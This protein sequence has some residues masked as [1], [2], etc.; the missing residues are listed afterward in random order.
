M[1]AQVVQFEDGRFMRVDFVRH[2]EEMSELALEGGGTI[3]VP[4]GRI[5]NWTDLG[6][7]QAA[8]AAPLQPLAGSGPWVQAA[9]DYAAVIARAAAKHRLHPALLTAMAEVES[10]F[11]PRAVSHKGAQGLLQLMPGTA[12]RFGVVDSFDPAQNVE[13][14]AEYISWLL[15]R[16]AG[17]A[18]L[19][20]AGYNAGEGKVERY[21]GIPPYSETRDY[22]FK[23]LA[24]FDRLAGSAR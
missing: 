1:G 22:V 3:S 19:A 4:T 13:G 14:G 10:A 21:D 8:P 17:R 15:D 5:V 23:V 9:G 6:Q 24:G 7:V 20:L 16:F 2:G 11:D 18:D 12:E